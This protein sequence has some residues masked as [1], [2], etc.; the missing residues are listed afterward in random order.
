MVRPFLL[1]LIALIP[2]VTLA[3]LDF[4]GR[5]ELQ[6]SAMAA[7]EFSYLLM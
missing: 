7:D 6:H 4:R 1:L 3:H 5:I 2:L